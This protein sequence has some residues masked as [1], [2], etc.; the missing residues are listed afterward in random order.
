MHL[1]HGLGGHD[2][3]VLNGHVVG[4]SKDPPDLLGHVDRLEGILGAHEVVAG[5]LVG[6]GEELGLHDARAEVGDLHV[7]G[8]V[9]AELEMVELEKFREQVC[10]MRTWRQKFIQAASCSAQENI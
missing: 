5:L 9:V 6:Q 2:Y 7:V 8:L 4:L 10:K 3:D 1:L